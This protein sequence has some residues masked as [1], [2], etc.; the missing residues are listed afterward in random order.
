MNLPSRHWFK[1]STPLA[2]DEACHRRTSP[3]ERVVSYTTISPL[4]PRQ[5]EVSGL[6]SVALFLNIAAY[7]FITSV[8]LYGAWTFLPA[9]QARRSCYLIG[10]EQINYNK[11]VLICPYFGQKMSPG[12]MAGVRVCFVAGSPNR[13]AALPAVTALG[14]TPT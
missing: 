1:R 14:D 11:K 2:P 9:M 6:F 8:L 7:S 10:F 13:C 4:L 3:Y 12:Q 5:V